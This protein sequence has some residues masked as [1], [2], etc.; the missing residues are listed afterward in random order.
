MSLPL[1]L[2]I[3]I[4]AYGS[5]LDIGHA[6]MWFGLGASMQQASDKIQPVSF[7]EYHIN[8][9]DLCRNTMIWDA[10]QT[11]ANWCLQVDSDTF[12]R[13]GSEAPADTGTDI[14]QMIRD[15]DRLATPEFR[16][17]GTV[18]L[19]PVEVNFPNSGVAMIGAPVRGR[20]VGDKGVCVRKLVVD[21][22]TG[23]HSAGA[24]ATL[25]ELANKVQ[26]IGRIGAAF[27]AVNLDWLRANWP[28]PPWFVMDHD[29]SQRPKNARGEDYTFCDGVHERGGVIL[30]DGRFVPS[31]VDRRKLVGEE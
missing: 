3:A 29:Y 5:K 22:A 28:K 16:A 26:P 25:E 23:S 2:A 19:K 11:E 6:A 1:K 4:P 20:G 14:V 8:G 31:H 24:E 13:S 21:P 10:L 12:Y 15:A 7:V 18:A 27:I 9:I 30:C 17:D